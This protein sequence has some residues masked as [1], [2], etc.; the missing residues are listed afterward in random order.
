MKSSREHAALEAL[1][2]HPPVAQPLKM[3]AYSDE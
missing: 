3:R 2:A 1:D